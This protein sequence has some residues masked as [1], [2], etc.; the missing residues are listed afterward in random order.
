MKK[1]FVLLL[2][3]VALLSLCACG[4]ETTK[5]SDIADNSS[6]ESKVNDTNNNTSDT[7]QKDGEEA[8]LG[9]WKHERTE[10][11]PFQMS[12]ELNAGGKGKNSNTD[13]EWSY[14]EA[15]KQISITIIYPDGTKSDSSNAKLTDGKLCWE[16]E[17]NIKT[18]SGDFV[19]FDKALF[20]K[21]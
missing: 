8:F 13:I 11:E 10:A 12:L 7:T 9:T 15:T 17:F 1:I 5:D 19:K 18:Q 16:R 20:V 14:D 2:C 3:L 4:G 21:Q 6:I